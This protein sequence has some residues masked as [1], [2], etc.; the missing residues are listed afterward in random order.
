MKIAATKSGVG[1]KP[2]RMSAVEDASRM[3]KGSHDEI[4]YVATVQGKK[5]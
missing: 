4:V 3:R 5:P 2:Y 1:D